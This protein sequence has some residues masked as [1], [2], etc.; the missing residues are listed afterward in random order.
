VTYPTND[1]TPFEQAAPRE[2]WDRELEDI[3][4]NWN[5]RIRRG[6]ILADFRHERMRQLDKWGPQ[7]HPDG[8][9]V[10]YWGPRRD[11]ARIVCDGN[12]ALGL[13]TWLDILRE[14]VY[15]ALAETDPKALEKE[16]VQ[17]GAVV[18]AWLEDI[19]SR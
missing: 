17:V 8:T 1:G 12:A 10:G 6:E 9:D 18:V 19:R 4:V 5:E 3:R 16:L 2:E 13:G 15:E 7:V 11:R 14:E